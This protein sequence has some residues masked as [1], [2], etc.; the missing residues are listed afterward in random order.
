MM[1]VLTITILILISTAVF[2]IKNE[3]HTSTSLTKAVTITTNLHFTGK[4]CTEC[5]LKTPVEGEDTL[6]KFGGNFN[7]LCWCHIATPGEYIHP[8][9]IEPSEDKKVRIP[10]DLPLQNG[11]MSCLTCHNIY[12]QCQN[13]F[14]YQMSNKRFLR[15]FPYAHRTDLCFRCHDEKK[16]KMLDP[17]NQ[18]DE[19]GNIVVKKC[20][21]CHV[22]KPD[23]NSA[24]YSS[25]KLHFKMV[26]FVGSLQALC[27]RCHGKHNHP[28]NVNHLLKPSFEILAMIKASERKLGAVFPLAKNGKITCATCHNPHE[29]GVIPDSNPASTGA[30]KN[31]RARLSVAKEL[32]FAC[33]DLDQ[34]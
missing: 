12:M 17:H 11:K 30:G 18:L 26:N 9:D 33:H 25:T 1:R 8:V 5:H 31:K 29:K 15:G 19:N 7:Q 4:Y 21:Y 24:T 2:A 27:E 22:E 6:L 20:L 10:E 3:Q 13:N 32:C 28:A 16:Y 34:M 23:E 14:E